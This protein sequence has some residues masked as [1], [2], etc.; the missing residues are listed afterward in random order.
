MGFLDDL[1]DLAKSVGEANKEI[2]T[3]KKEVVASFSGFADDAKKIINPVIEEP[4]SS[5]DSEPAK[6]IETPATD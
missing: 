4:E 3:I 2:K 1:V 5:E 6:E